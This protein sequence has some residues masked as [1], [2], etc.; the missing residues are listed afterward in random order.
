MAG[1][2]DLGGAS[3]VLVLPLDA[4]DIATPADAA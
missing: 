2:N 1:W 3:V 4:S